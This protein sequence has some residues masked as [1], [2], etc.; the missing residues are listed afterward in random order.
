MKIP[1]I[2]IYLKIKYLFLGL[3]KKLDIS[4]KNVEKKLCQLMDKKYIQFSGM[5][6]TSFLVILEYLN[7]KYPNKKELI[8][9]SYNLKEMVDIARLLNFNIKLI[10]IKKDIGIVDIKNLKEKIN[11]NTAAILFT[12]MFND[13]EILIDLKDFC[14]KNDIL[15]IEDNAIYFGNYSYDGEKKFF[16]GSFGDVSIL[17]FGIMKNISALYGGALLTSDEELHEFANNRISNFQSFPKILYFKQIIIFLLLK[18]FLSKYIYNFFFFYVIQLAT[19]KKIQILLNLIYPSLRFKKKK[20]IPKSYYSKISNYTLKIVDL[21]LSDQNFNDETKIRMKNNLFYYSLFKKIEDIK[22]I[23][24]KDFNFQNLLDFPILVKNKDKLVKYLFEKGLE[25]RIH[26]YSNCEEIIETNDNENS[27]Y[28]EKNLICLPS[29]A[30]INE[31]KIKEYQTEIIKFY[32]LS[33][34]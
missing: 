26:F 33:N 8:I 17:S 10:D 29:H 5:C 19:T 21:I 7:K 34:E 20:T 12:N 1:R 23:E 14:K 2:K 31:E 27:D 22:I 18:L 16:S 15:L 32:K 30:K 6:R 9:C 13:S 11:E 3:F 28:Y 24:M 25:T 4:K